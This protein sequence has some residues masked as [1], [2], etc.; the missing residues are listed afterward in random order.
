MRRRCRCSVARAAE[1]K[2]KAQARAA[3]LGVS[4]N[5]LFRTALEA[6]LGPLQAAP[7]VA[8]NAPCPCGSG[9]KFKRCCGA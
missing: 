7:A 4:L 6:Y 3:E 2:A 5:A 1:L 9:K 8:R